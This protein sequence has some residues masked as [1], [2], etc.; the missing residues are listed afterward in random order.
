MKTLREWLLARYGHD[1]SASPHFREVAAEDWDIEIRV[2]DD[3][4]VVIAGDSVIADYDHGE[5][6]VLGLGEAEEQG[7]FG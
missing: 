2:T 1:M 6:F 4:D 3:P 5:P 7:L